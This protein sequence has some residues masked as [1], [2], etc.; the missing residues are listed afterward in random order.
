M[1]RRDRPGREEPKRQLTEGKSP[2]PTAEDCI[3]VIK[4]LTRRRVL[5]VLHDAGEARSPKET[6]EALGAP[7]SHVS[8]HFRML[9]KYRAVALTDTLQ[10]RGSMEH[11]YIST[12]GD[13]D[14]IAMFLQATQA[15]DEKGAGR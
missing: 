4:H 8:Y 11:F 3:E 12:V 5:R 7:L 1:P 2:E 9:K 10:R 15:G 6:S 14:A 13:N